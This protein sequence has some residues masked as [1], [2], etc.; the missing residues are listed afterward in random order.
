M[1]KKEVLEYVDL[2][3]LCEYLDRKLKYKTDFKHYIYKGDK[4]NQFYIRYPGFTLIEIIDGKISNVNN[5]Q[6]NDFY[7]L[8]IGDILNKI[9]R[10]IFHNKKEE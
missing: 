1:S 10:F 2:K 6:V 8:Q 5:T 7:N 4:D 9:G 3:N